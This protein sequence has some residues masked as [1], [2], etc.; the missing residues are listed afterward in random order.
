MF[1]DELDVSFLHSLSHNAYALRE[2]MA[3]VH[4]RG[5]QFPVV[6]ADRTIKL[7]THSDNL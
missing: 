5:R 7:R 3:A 4:G 6:R 2:A 1:T